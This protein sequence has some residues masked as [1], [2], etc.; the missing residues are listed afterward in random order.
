VNFAH[1][2]YEESFAAAFE[3]VCARNVRAIY[4]GH[5]APLLADCNTR[6]QRSLEIVTN[7][8]R[9]GCGLLNTTRKVNYEVV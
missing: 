7:R 6:L 1:S 5:G 8:V 2:T 9:R 3:K 4:F